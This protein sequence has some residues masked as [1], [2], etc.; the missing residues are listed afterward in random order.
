MSLQNK[1]RPTCLEEFYGNDE[2]VSA[3][4]KLFKRPKDEIPHSFLFTG[5]AGGGKTTLAYIIKNIIECSDGDFKYFNAGNTRGIETI[6]EVS[7][8]IQFAPM[9]GK[10]KMYTFDEAGGITPDAL[11]A[12]LLLTENPP[13][14]V[15]I[16][17]CTSEPF[18]LTDADKRRLHIYD[19]KPMTY[20][21]LSGLCC[22]IIDAEEMK[23]F[24][25]E[26]I[27]MIVKE[28]NGSAGV[29]L[30][31]LDQI[32]D[33]YSDIPASKR[34]IETAG[35]DVDSQTIDLCRELM[36]FKIDGDARFKKCCSIIKTIKSE[37]ESVRYAI[38]GY[39][40]KVMLNNGN[41][42]IA[43]MI[44]SFENNYYY[45]KQAGLTKSVFM[46]CQD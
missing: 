15:Y 3:L 37:P 30:K 14:Y 46:A 36:N 32:K 22:D 4:S 9:F 33:V 21:E 6:R 35:L 27:E 25:Q 20:S 5:L 34:L 2:I 38:L 24:P 7:D 41:S 11:R 45:S 43:L 13:D 23:D 31:I 18:K 19:V 42:K 10:V 16:V 12:M 8:D 40:N 39:L 44:E 28:S 1:Y 26:L 29:A 17:M